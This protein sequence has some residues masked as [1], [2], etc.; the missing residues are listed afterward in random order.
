MME[1]RP[2]KLVFKSEKMDKT[3]RRCYTICD[4]VYVWC[5]WAT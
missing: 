3:N 1:S 2:R 5:L 4:W